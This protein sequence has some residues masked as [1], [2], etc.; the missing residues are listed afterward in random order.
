MPDDVAAANPWKVAVKRKSSL[1]IVNAFTEDA[2][3]SDLSWVPDMVVVG[4]APITAEAYVLAYLG[5]PREWSWSTSLLHDQRE[6]VLK[7]ALA[8]IVKAQLPGHEKALG[9]LGAGPLE[10]MM[11][12]KLLDD[13]QSWLPFEPAM[14]YALG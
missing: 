2:I 1:K 4:E 8:I 5:A 14:R 3:A 7:R 13:L 9:Q 10:D 6:A 11:S 12:D